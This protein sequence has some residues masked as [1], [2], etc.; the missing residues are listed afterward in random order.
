MNIKEYIASGI[1]ESCVLGLASEEERKEFEQLCAK[2]PELVEARTHFE[3]ILEKQ[4]MDNAEAPPVNSK[5]NIW[6]AI[7]NAQASGTSK[8]IPMETVAPRRSTGMAWLAAASIILMLTAGYFVYDFYKKNNDLTKINTE[9]AEHVREMDSTMAARVGQQAGM[10]PTNVALI[11]LEP[12][13]P[14]APSA[15]IC[16][17]TTSSDVWL[18][19]KNVPRLASDKQYQLWAL[20]DSAGK[21]NAT[22]LGL[23]DGGK[24]RL[25]IQMKNARKADAFAVTI[26]KAGNAGGPDLSQLQVM[27]KTNKLPLRPSE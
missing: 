22:S 4:A 21:N 10:M 9:M 26:E 16:W 25:F 6:T 23:F 14:A 17:D 2:Y 15:T 19:L 27:G 8:V 5:A 7:Q 20:I 12:M 11:T 18:V 1:I 13:T 24:E 3:L